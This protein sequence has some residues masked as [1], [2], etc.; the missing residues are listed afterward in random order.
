MAEQTGGYDYE[1]VE[2]PSDDLI[3]TIC[4]CP[5]KEPH[6]S[7]CCGYTFCKSCI[8][9]TKR[10]KSISSAC[11]ICRNKDFGKNPFFN[12]QA[13]RIIKNLYVYCSNKEKGC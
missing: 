12:K 4:Q 5:S 7:A 8:E 13:D 10:A 9:A 11:P 6:L 2:A 3:C 1:F